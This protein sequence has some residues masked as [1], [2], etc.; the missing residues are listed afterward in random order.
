M[1]LN[2]WRQL[3]EIVSDPDLVLL[4]NRSG[5]L[6]YVVASNTDGIKLSVGFEYKKEAPNAI[7][8]GFRQATRTIDEIIR[9]GLY[10]IIEG[11]QADD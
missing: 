5:K 1:K 9:G 4:D 11:S 2:E 7:V 10:T 6:I 8:S 3:P